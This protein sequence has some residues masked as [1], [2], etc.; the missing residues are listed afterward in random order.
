MP[1]VAE[2]W[3][4]NGIENYLASLK[5]RDNDRMWELN[6]SGYVPNENYNFIDT[7]QGSISSGVA[8]I[9]GDLQG[10]AADNN[11]KW[12]ENE[13][14]YAADTLGKVAAR[15]QYIGTPESDGWASFVFNKGVEA[16]GSS[17]PSLIADVGS[18]VAINAAIGTVAGPEGTLLGGMTGLLG[19]GAKFI[20]RLARGAEKGVELSKAADRAYK[21]GRF[22]IGATT[23]GL[24][25]NIANAGDTYRTG[26]SRGMDHKEAWEARNE[27]FAQGFLP[28]ILDYSVDKAFRDAPIEG[29]LG[30]MASKPGEKVAQKAVQEATEQAANKLGVKGAMKAAFTSKPMKAVGDVGM[31]MLSEGVTE[32][33]QT[34]IQEQ[35]LHNPKYADTH[36]YNPY[37]WTDEMWDSA[38]DAA[39]GAGFLGTT[40]KAGKAIKNAVMG[41]PS[42]VKAEDI[43]ADTESEIVDTDVPTEEELAEEHLDLEGNP[44][45]P[46]TVPPSAPP[47]NPQ[48]TM[49]ANAIMA[50]SGNA[51]NNQD[52]IM[53]NAIMAHNAPTNVGV[54]PVEVNEDEF[55]LEAEPTS[56]E[57]EEVEDTS[58]PYQRA[59]DSFVESKKD[60]YLPSEM[61]E[62][63]RTATAV[64]D[65]Y[66]A[67]WN[68]LGDEAKSKTSKTALQSSLKQRYLDAGLN[69]SDASLMAKYVG[70]DMKNNHDSEMFRKRASKAVAAADAL[71][72]P[73][74]DNQR[75]TLTSDHPDKLTL[76]KIEKQVENRTNE[77][78]SARRQQEA[79][80][81]ARKQEE[82]RIAKQQAR[83]AERQAKKEQAEKERQDKAAKEQKAKD[84]EKAKED[85][86]V[87]AYND[88]F[89]SSGNYDYLMYLHDHDRKIAERTGRRI[90]KAMANRKADK[91]DGKHA[92]PIRKYLSEQGIKE[93]DEY[94]KNQVDKIVNHVESTEKEWDEAK[95]QSKG[96]LNFV[97]NKSSYR[98]YIEKTDEHLLKKYDSLD[99][100]DHKYKDEVEKVHREN[101]EELRKLKARGFDVQ[102]LS[103]YQWLPKE[104]REE[105]GKELYGPTN[106]QIAM[107]E[108]KKKTDLTKVATPTSQQVKS[109]E[110]SA[111]KLETKQ[112][113]QEAPK[114]EPQE[115]T[116][117]KAHWDADAKIDLFKHLANDPE[118]GFYDFSQ[119]DQQEQIEKVSTA[120]QNGEEVNLDDVTKPYRDKVIKARADE[121]AATEAAE[122]K[123]EADAVRA[124]ANAIAAENDQKRRDEEVKNNHIQ[125]VIHDKPKTEE[126]TTTEETTPTEDNQQTVENGGGVQPLTIQLSTMKK[127]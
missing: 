52:T 109:A 42:E 67:L 86:E 20:Y 108:Y 14:K 29:A 71:G 54:Q 48:D 80:E 104:L 75:A 97:R 124:E 87:K 49:M 45:P 126:K 119:E 117:T 123:A 84:D 66:H 32:A 107:E 18:Q 56:A 125:L 127:V 92:K 60:R 74:T 62:V 46:P 69:D 13:S 63:I 70:D 65:E 83:E 89:V 91:A 122:K 23:G 79:K 96:K 95:D 37:S 93:N 41:S 103:A 120:Y 106:E 111:Q 114:E 98:A 30:A 110:E 51:Q 99:K 55:D 73:V 22:A 100:R 101:M 72:I 28:A 33:W 12:L 36:I 34:Q 112:T 16:L 50:Q 31:G 9:F 3:G 76:D 81:V 43:T 6:A 4:A 64:T 115:S 19:G 102:K 8:G 121:K 59:M 68:D 24:V 17:V 94:T 57:V 5:Q 21:A 40:F 27:A 85:A 15:N 61:D 7:L 2:L 118:V 58:Y 78:E 77:I 116:K 53:A 113:V 82:E 88:R 10:Y 90:S 1:S 38:K 35:A 44:T 39:I 105:L 47:T 26:L 11:W 25:E